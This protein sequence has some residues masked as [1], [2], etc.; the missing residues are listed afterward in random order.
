MKQATK[1]GNMIRK[2]R[3]SLALTQSDVAAKVGVKP[4][5]IS[6]LEQD[7]RTPSM[8]VLWRLVQVLKFNAD[9]DRY[10]LFVGA[11]PSARKWLRSIGPLA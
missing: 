10:M 5:Y 1:I 11:Y 3:E 7:E 9:V 6:Y 8:D 2:R 4:S